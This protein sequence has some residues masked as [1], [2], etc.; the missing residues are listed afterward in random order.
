M[1]RVA[2]RAVFD[3][4]TR[5]RLVEGDLD[6]ND[7]DR[8]EAEHRIEERFDRIDVRLNRLLWALATAA[9]S[10]ATTSVVIVLTALSQ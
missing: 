3:V 6:R 10:L 1:S 5:L 4:A 9:V 8:V 7:Y 2:D